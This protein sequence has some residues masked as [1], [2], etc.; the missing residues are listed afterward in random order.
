MDEE[1]LGEIPMDVRKIL[2]L[3]RQLQEETTALVRDH[4]S[5]HRCTRTTGQPCP[6]IMRQTGK[7]IKEADV[8][9]ELF[10]LAIRHE[11]NISP[12]KPISIRSNWRVVAI[13]EEAVASAQPSDKSPLI[14]SISIM[15]EDITPDKDE[16]GH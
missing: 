11:I 2:G 10:I 4:E 1:V 6:E 14:I 16:I 15:P 3:H 13:S 7:M 5:T 8:L 12:Q 9:F